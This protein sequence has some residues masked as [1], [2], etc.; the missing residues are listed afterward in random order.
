MVLISICTYDYYLRPV[1]DYQGQIYM[2]TDNGKSIRLRNLCK[3]DPTGPIGIRGRID[4]MG[5]LGDKG[6]NI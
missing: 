6:E 2:F 3:I 1:L 4:V 5:P